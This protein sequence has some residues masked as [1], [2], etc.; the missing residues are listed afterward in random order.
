MFG[1]I[2]HFINGSEV[3]SNS[4][5]TY[6]VINPATKQVIA[7]A[8]LGNKNDVDKAVK[9]A[10]DAWPK[11]KFMKAIDRVRILKRIADK[12][13]ENRELLATQ[14][15]TESGWPYTRSK[16]LHVERCMNW[17]HYFASTIDKLSGRVVPVDPD[18]LSFTSY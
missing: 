16:N 2:T 15:V 8:C 11:W 14:E 7:D 12:I 4:G 9:A 13:G 5:E 10:R 3:C 6:Q 17:F 18:Y 1:R